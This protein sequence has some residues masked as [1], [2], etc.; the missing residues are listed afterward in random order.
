MVIRQNGLK[1]L[2]MGK[3]KKFALYLMNEAPEWMTIIFFAF[4]MAI[5]I[6][7]VLLSGVGTVCLFSYLGSNLMGDFFG[8]P[9]GGFFGLFIYLIIFLFVAIK[10]MD[11]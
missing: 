4:I 10:I 8:E 1:N 3:I 7:F 2:M 6:P 11:S 9:I 5:L